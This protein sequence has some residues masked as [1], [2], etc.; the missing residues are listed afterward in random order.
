MHKKEIL[1]HILQDIKGLYSSVSTRAKVVE[2]REYQILLKMVELEERRREL[3]YKRQRRKSTYGIERNSPYE[4]LAQQKL[5]PTDNPSLS[6]KINRSIDRSR[7]KSR[8]PTSRWR[9][10]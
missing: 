1:D 9:R 7:I 4:E 2:E 6:K 8:R 5:L 10:I 3:S